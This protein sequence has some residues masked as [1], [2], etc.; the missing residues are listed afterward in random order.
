MC[1]RDRAWT[2]WRF[3]SFILSGAFLV[4]LFLLFFVLHPLQEAQDF[5]L[6]PDVYKRQLVLLLH[7]VLPAVSSLQDATFPQDV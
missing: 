4:L 2:V 6:Q 5:A 7:L 3:H 1:I